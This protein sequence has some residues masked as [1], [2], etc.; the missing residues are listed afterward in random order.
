VKEYSYT[1]SPTQAEEILRA[2]GGKRY[3]GYY[4]VRCPAHPDRDPSLKIAISSE[5][6][7]LLWNCKAG[8]S[9][10]VVMGALIERGLLPRS[11]PRFVNKIERAIV[12]TEWNGRAGA[13]DLAVL[14]A[15]LSIARLAGDGMYHAS[16]RVLAEL[17]GLCA[18]T[19][20]SSSERLV[21]AGWLVRHDTR[22]LGPRQS[23]PSRA[24]ATCWGLKVSDRNVTVPYTPSD[25]LHLPSRESVRDGYVSHDLWRWGPGL[26]KSKAR[27]YAALVA[28]PKTSDDLAREL[29]VKV[30][31]IRKHLRKLAGL[32]I[33]ERASGRRW[34]LVDLCNLDSVALFLGVLGESDRQREHHLEERLI[35]RERSRAPMSGSGKVRVVL[36]KD[37][38]PEFE[39]A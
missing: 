29:S 28:G 21:E 10:K 35:W 34:Q 26:G 14:S 1:D 37:S 15:H 2:L 6:G 24:R 22:F 39:V 38:E 7:K 25:V 23:L 16:A 5:S 12:C 30:A 13:T 19:A 20:L 8:C 11:V 31:T 3:R 32:R 33:V 36:D 4:M 27:V 9:N 17:A 18:S